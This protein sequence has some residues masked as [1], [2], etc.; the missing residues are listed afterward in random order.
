MDVI[1]TPKNRSFSHG[2]PI[3]IASVARVYRGDVTFMVA[4]LTTKGLKRLRCLA[5]DRRDW[6]L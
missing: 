2:F 4:Q 5:D 1:K 6:T 3:E